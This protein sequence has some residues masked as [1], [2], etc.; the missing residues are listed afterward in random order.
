SRTGEGVLVDVSLL[1][2]AVWT[3]GPDLTATTILGKD[4]PTQDARRPLSNLLIGSY[5][6]GDGRWLLLNMLD[7]MR[8][9]APTCR[10]LGLDELIDDPRYADTAGRSEHRQALYE[11][12]RTTI[13]ERPLAELR[14][15][16]SAEDTIWSVMASPTEVIADPQVEANRYLAPHPDHE[17]A[18]LATGPCQF[19]D[20]LP[21]VRY[22]APAVGEHTDEILAAAGVAEDEIR[23][24][25][26]AGAV[27]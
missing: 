22:H 14:T 23:R 15:R 18:R 1:N 12:I 11:Q 20:E 24:L 21:A 7:D 5:L 25:R 27:A 4:P 2:S 16:L 19:D 26:D 6:T 17:R 10:A 8:H 9:W 3:L 13:A